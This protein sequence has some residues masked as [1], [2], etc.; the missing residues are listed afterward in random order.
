MLAEKQRWLAAKEEP[1]IE[2]DDSDADDDAAAPH[3]LTERLNAE[4]MM[5]K[6]I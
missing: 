5:S 3:R 1:A 2:E 4:A 6:T